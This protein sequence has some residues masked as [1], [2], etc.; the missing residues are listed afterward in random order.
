MALL[1]DYE[2]AASH[3]ATRRALRGV[4]EKWKIFIGRRVEI[5][6]RKR[7]VLRPRNFPLEEEKGKVFYDRDC[8]FFL[9]VI[10]RAYL[11]NSL[12]GV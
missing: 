6:T 2:S 9:G 4:I 1:S 12:T 8:L 10:E 11:T 7:I 5:M 3:S